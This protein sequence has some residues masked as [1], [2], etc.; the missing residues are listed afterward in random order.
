[1][2][3]GCDEQGNKEL[4]A[5]SDGDRESAASWEETLLDLTQRGLTIPPKLAVGDSALG[6]WKALD[7][8]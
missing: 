6:F 5:L 3:I 1:M 4:I 2:I 8:L 7:K